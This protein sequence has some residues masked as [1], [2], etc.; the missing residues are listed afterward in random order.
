MASCNAVLRFLK[1]VVDHVANLRRQGKEV[2]VGLRSPWSSHCGDK[3]AFDEFLSEEIRYKLTHRYR[4]YKVA[5]C[6][7][8]HGNTWM[9]SVASI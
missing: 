1:F 4:L 9:T 8:S 2:E 6:I 7:W 5:V 3:R